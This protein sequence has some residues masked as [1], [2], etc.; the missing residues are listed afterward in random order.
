MYRRFLRPTKNLE[1]LLLNLK[2]IKPK[3]ETPLPELKPAIIPPR[4]RGLPNPS[5]ELMDLDDFFISPNAK[6]D[7]LSSKC[8]DGDLEFYIVELEK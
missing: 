8:K 3:F 7:I 2:I 6:L 5:L 1:P 4:F